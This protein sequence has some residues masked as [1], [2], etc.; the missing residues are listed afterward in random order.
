MKG[1]SSAIKVEIFREGTATFAVL[2]G[3]SVP[4]L[5]DRLRQWQPEFECLYSGE[6]KPDLAEVAPYLVRMEPDTEFANWV[7][8]EGW[9]NHWG[10]FVVADAD[11]RAVRQHLRRFLTVHDESGKP[12]LFRYYDPRVLRVY[13]PTCNAGELVELFGPIV[14]Y[15]AEGEEPD[16]VLRFEVRGAELERRETQLSAPKPN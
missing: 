8:A 10:I 12:L 5:L 14:Y 11:L 7:L 3:A 16:T 2:D 6:V 13:L 4:R 1:R 9:G 15:V